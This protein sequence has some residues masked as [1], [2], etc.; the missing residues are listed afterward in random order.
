MPTSLCKDLRPGVGSACASGAGTDTSSPSARAV[1]VPLSNDD[2]IY[3]SC[4]ARASLGAVSHLAIL[5][6][7]RGKPSVQLC[8]LDRKFQIA[9]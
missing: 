8:I 7:I 1:S 5:V 6:G 9:F 2:K 4:G 3:L